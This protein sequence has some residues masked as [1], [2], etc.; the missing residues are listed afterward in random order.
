MKK[1]TV[2]LIEQCSVEYQRRRD[3]KRFDYDKDDYRMAFKR[4]YI[5]C[6]VTFCEGVENV[7]Q[8]ET[9]PRS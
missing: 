8:L 4:G 2:D 3:E 7:E 9:K 5:A 1:P 6:A